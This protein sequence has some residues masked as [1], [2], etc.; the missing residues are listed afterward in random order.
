[1]TSLL[2]IGGF[3]LLVIALS[4]LARSRDQHA[5]SAHDRALHRGDED[6]HIY[7][8][9]DDELVH[10][11]ESCSGCA[12][13]R[14]EELRRKGVRIDDVVYGKRNTGDLAW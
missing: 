12:Q 7:Y 3:I 4:S 6:S 13:L 11:R 10:E 14:V 9:Q 2:I 5:V 1:M 8:Y